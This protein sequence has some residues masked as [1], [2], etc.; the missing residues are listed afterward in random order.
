MADNLPDYVHSLV[1]ETI[2]AQL[3]SERDEAIARAEAAEAELATIKFAAHMP[4]GYDHGLPSWIEQYLYAAYIGAR[5][6]DIV[7]EQINNGRLIFP[8]A[9]IYAEAAALRQR[10]AELE[11]AQEE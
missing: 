9:P 4:D 8:E 2:E 3:T 5:Q 7:I 1:A 11:A 10:V 6:S